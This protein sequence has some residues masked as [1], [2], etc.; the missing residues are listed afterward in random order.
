MRYTQKSFLPKTTFLQQ[1]KINKSSVITWK[2]A[3]A[4]ALC[5]SPGGSA[6]L[7]DAGGLLLQ[8]QLLFTDCPLPSASRSLPSP[9]LRWDSPSGT[10]WGRAIPALPE[11]SEFKIISSHLLHSPQER[12]CAAVPSTPL[13]F[14]VCPLYLQRIKKRVIRTSWPAEAALIPAQAAF[15]DSRTLDRKQKRKKKVAPH[16]QETFSFVRASVRGPSSASFGQ[17]SRPWGEGLGQIVRT[18]SLPAMGSRVAG[19]WG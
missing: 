3:C 13:H 7:W 8:A 4:S 17:E 10:F 12:L 5:V 2:C 18:Q 15:S 6:T 19:P 14:K 9:T 16:G 11:F 1:A